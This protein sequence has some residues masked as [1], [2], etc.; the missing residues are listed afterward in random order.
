MSANVVGSAERAVSENLLNC[1]KMASVGRPTLVFTSDFH[2]NRLQVESSGPI[3][4]VAT[5]TLTAEENVSTTEPDLQTKSARDAQKE[6]SLLLLV[7]DNQAD[8]F[9]VEQAIEFY[10]VPVKVVVAED[11]ELACQYF[12]RAD[13]DENTL[14]PAVLVLDLNLPKRSGTEVLDRVRKSPKCRDIAVVIM[15]SSD[16]IEDRRNASRLGADRYFRKPTS[17]R[18][19][20]QIGAVLNEVLKEHAS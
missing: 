15:T 12:D 5:E 6:G 13:A 10:Q 1:G 14:C 16:S 2:K 8:V 3:A 7:E 19:F 9:L 20:L 11:G 18:E 4:L 17:Y